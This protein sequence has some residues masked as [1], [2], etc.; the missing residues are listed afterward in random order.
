MLQEARNEL[1]S[2]GDVLDIGCGTGFWLSALESAGASPDHLFGVDVQPERV[3]AA[4][5]RVPRAS[6]KQADA[7]SLPFSDAGFSVVLLFTLLSSL[8]DDDDTV[9]ALREARRMLRPSGLLLCYEPRLPNPLNPRVRRVPNERF[10]MASVRPR[11]ERS[12]TLLPPLARRLGPATDAL[13][14]RLARV[15]LLRSHRL[16]AYRRV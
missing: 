10:D 14:P 16:V 13:Y 12:L 8:A 9:R 11:H 2:D 6:V 1:R 4:S 15:P 7:R 5:H 3:A